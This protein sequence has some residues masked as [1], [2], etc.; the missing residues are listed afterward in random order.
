MFKEI[1]KKRTKKDDILDAGIRLFARVPFTEMTIAA[2][3][4]EAGCGHSLVYHYFRNV[5]V[6]YDEGVNRVS[7]HFLTVINRVVALNVPAELIF[8]GIVSSLVEALKKQPM[9]FYY[10]NLIAYRHDA[11]PLNPAVAAVQEQWMSMLLNIVRKGQ[12]NGRIISI[13]TAEEIIRGLQTNFRGIVSSQIL[14]VPE[15][16]NTFKASDVYLPYLKGV[17]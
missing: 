1:E 5:N 6:L 14:S 3:A 4:R 8:V 2:V 17:H 12:K 11:T 10:V 16:K 13:L 15:E 7:N 9:T